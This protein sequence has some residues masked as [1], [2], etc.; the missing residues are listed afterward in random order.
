MKPAP[1]PFAYFAYETLV[2][3]H[4]SAVPLSRQRNIETIVRRMVQFGRDPRRRL[5]QRAGRQELDFRGL[6]KPAARSASSFESS[7]R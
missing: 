5:Q 2:G 6:K 1:A 3:G 7:S 4:K